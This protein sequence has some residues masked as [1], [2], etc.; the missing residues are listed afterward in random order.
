V[1]DDLLGRSVK[2]PSCNTTF[3]ASAAEGDVPAVTPI[4]PQGEPGAAMPHPP[5]T[6]PREREYQ[7]RAGYGGEPTYGPRRDPLSATKAP[8]IC[9][10]VIGILGLLSSLYM[11]VSL[12]ATNPEQIEKQL[13]Q[14]KMDPQQRDVGRQVAQWMTG[15]PGLTFFGAFAV[16]GLII[17][18]G[19]V[20]MLIGR[21]RW[22]AILGSLLAIINVCCCFVGAPFGIWSLVVLMRPEVREA[23]NNPDR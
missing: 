19:A 10:L 2:C 8:A 11:L 15:P 4:A 12:L 1:P 17:T 16:A 5:S 18:L 6:L 3:T 7:E 21:M 14:Q 20:M 13:E 23:F 22:L 9:L